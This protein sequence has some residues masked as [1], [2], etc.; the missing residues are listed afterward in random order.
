MELQQHRRWAHWAAAVGTIVLLIGFG[1]LIIV[2]LRD[3]EEMGEGIRILIPP[4]LV[5]L[6]PAMAVIANYKTIQIRP[7][8]VRIT[9]APFPTKFNVFIPRDKVSLIYARLAAD[10]G[11]D[12]G[13]V[14][15][16][17][18]GIES[19]KG[20]QFDISEGYPSVEPA[21]EQARAIAAILNAS[22]SKPPIPIEF[23]QTK[24]DFTFVRRLLTWLVVVIA[25]ILLG[26][27]WEV[28]AQ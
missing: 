23:A 1:A 8:G 22:N 10:G 11:E 16:F 18:A 7:E 3:P 2:T 17:T 27:Y 12:A 15:L 25:A 13:Y 28:T 5:M 20:Q 24:R 19:A 6:Y 4:F 26:A 21:W 9:V 14:K